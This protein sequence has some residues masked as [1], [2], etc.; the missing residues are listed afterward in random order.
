MLARNNISNFLNANNKL[1]ATVTNDLVATCAMFS[2]RIYDTFD[3]PPGLWG[4][5]YS[6]E[7]ASTGYRGAAYGRNY[8]S[9][10]TEIIFVHRGTILTPFPEGLKNIEGCIQIAMEKIPL[11]HKS[12]LEFWNKFNNKVYEDFCARHGDPYDLTKDNHDKLWK[13][14]WNM[15]NWAKPRMVTTGHSLGAILSDL[16]RLDTLED[17]MKSIT[18]ENPGSL[19]MVKKEIQSRQPE[20]YE[21]YL[22]IARQFCYVYQ[23]GVNLINTCNEQTAYRT[24]R[25]KGLE[26]DYYAFSGIPF[27]EG[28][29]FPVTSSYAGNL[30][31]VVGNTLDQHQIKIIDEFLRS[32]N[33]NYQNF[34]E[35]QNPIGA[36]AGYIDYLEAHGKSTYWDAYFREVWK[37]QPLTRLRFQNYIPDFIYWCFRKLEEIQKEAK[38]SLL[39]NKSILFQPKE[40][41]IET[42]ELLKSFVIVENPDQQPLE[43]EKKSK[44]YLM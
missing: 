10:N 43:N 39:S 23:G 1:A 28:P 13:D 27:I 2:S 16:C 6:Y 11:Q 35:I 8:L 42:D 19:P 37:N 33:Y 31:Y 41:E 18:F 3:P 14:Y 24:F 29:P 26:Y 32:G 36:Q 5:I 30:F 25:I 4:L 22:S 20:S 15:W 38:S 17:T 12:A 34:E 40:K 7:D 44:C 9:P 21:F